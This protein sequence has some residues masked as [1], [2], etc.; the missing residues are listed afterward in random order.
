LK[1]KASGKG[2]ARA[3]PRDDWAPPRDD[4]EG[5]HSYP[6]EKPR[7]GKG[8]GKSKSLPSSGEVEECKIFVGG[9]PMDATEE[10][11]EAHFKSWGDVQ[12][13]IL[14]RKMGES[15]KSRGFGFVTFYDAQAARAV[16][17]NYDHNMFEGKWIDC[18]FAVADEKGKGG[19]KGKG[20][21]G[22][23]G[24]TK[25]P[26]D[27][28]ATVIADGIPDSLLQEDLTQFFEFYGAVKEVQLD[29]G[30][31]HVT[32]ASPETAQMVLSNTEPVEIHGTS[33][34][35]RAPADGA[36]QRKSRRQN[37]PTTDKVFV[38]NVPEDQTEEKM[39]NYYGQFGTV[40]ELHLPFDMDTAKIRGFCFITFETAEAAEKA[41]WNNTIGDCRL[42]YGQ[43]RGGKAAEEASSPTD[44]FLKVSGLPQDPKQRDIFK[45]FFNYSLARIRDLDLEAIVEFCSAGECLKAF[46]EKQ[47]GRMGKERVILSGATREDFVAM[48]AAQEAIG[49]IGRGNK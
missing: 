22:E 35:L 10:M 15:Q 25:R 7:E 24:S 38:M 48:K 40:K 42:D 21:K 13:V 29:G 28:A 27:D 12:D 33:V 18:K 11:I 4:W 19:G 14:K 45:L 2:S 20:K 34:A 9:L 30:S 8:K 5:Q 49:I 36:G 44:V 16:V 17:E 39:A 37:G 47:G 41:V 32:F 23:D 6:P 26:A 31:A 3:P 1:G 43:K 46:K